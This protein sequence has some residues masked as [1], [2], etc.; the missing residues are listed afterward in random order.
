MTVTSCLSWDRS[1]GKILRET[2]YNSS[3]LRDICSPSPDPS[4]YV[5]ALKRHLKETVLSPD[6]A[7]IFFQAL[8]P[9]SIRVFLYFNSLNFKVGAFWLVNFYIFKICRICLLRVA[10]LLK[11]LCKLRE[12]GAS[13]QFTMH[14]G[15][16]MFP[17]NRAKQRRWLQKT[18][19]KELST[20]TGRKHY[21]NRRFSR[22]AVF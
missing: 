6:Q 16:Q 4:W 18:S 20:N 22:I 8:L 19:N 14:H 15:M 17:S 11:I 21:E 5:Q 13:I 2:F 10:D 7:C 12:I 3:R 1:N 9:K